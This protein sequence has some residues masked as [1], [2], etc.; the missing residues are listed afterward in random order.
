ML[1]RLGLQLARRLDEWHQGG[2]DIGGL[3][4][5]QIVAQLSDGF[6]KRQAL[7]IAH[8][9]ADFTKNKIRALGFVQNEFL[10][11]IGNV[12]DNL[13]RAAQIVAPA[14]LGQDLL[15]N[16]TRGDIVTLARGYAREALVMAQIQVGLGTVI[17]DVDFAVLGGAHGSWINVQ[18]GVK[19]AQANGI[20]TRLQQSAQGRRCQSLT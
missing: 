20:A 13:H 1:G 4:A 5:W 6:Q 17:G 7:D 2:V 12:G 15:I 19:L 11:G 18:V 8:G 16:P 9:A 14:F 3:A 10:D